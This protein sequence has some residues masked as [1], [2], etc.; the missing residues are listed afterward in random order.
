MYISC[1]RQRGLELGQCLLQPT[2]VDSRESLHPCESLPRHTLTLTHQSRHGQ[3]ESFA[4]VRYLRLAGV[5]SYN[6]AAWNTR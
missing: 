4:I 5:D 6:V 2:N 3:L 1:V